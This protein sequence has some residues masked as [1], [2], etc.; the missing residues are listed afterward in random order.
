MPPKLTLPGGA[1]IKDWVLRA[2]IVQGTQQIYISALWYWGS[3]LVKLSSAG[4]VTSTT[5]PKHIITSI[6]LPIAALMWIVGLMLLVGLPQ[7]YRSDPGKVPSFYKSIFRRKIIL[8]FFVAVAVQNYW[9]SA[10]YGRNWRYL[11]TTQH[12]PGWAIAALVVAFFIVIWAIFLVILSKLSKSH[13]W[14]LP[15]FAI[16]LGAPRWCQMLWGTSNVGQYLPW[17]GSALTSAILGRCL[18]LWLGVLDAL[19]GVGFGMIL[20]QTMTRFH[21]TFTLL[22]AQVLGSI[23]TILARLTAPDNTGPG[24][25]FPNFALGTEG[26]GY[27]A[28]WVGLMMQI[29]IC[30]GFAAFFR[31]EQ[32]SKP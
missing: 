5:T 2:C 23:A 10:P 13:S 24:T 16:G 28:F 32:L 18:W 15:V 29:G 12:A 25:V 7:Y 19:Q 26:L 11:W 31:K 4:A 21:I 17:A 3:A 1:P 30:V 6:T 9:L 20:L 27:W 22:A 14:I 8:W